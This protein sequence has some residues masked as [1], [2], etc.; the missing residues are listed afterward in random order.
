MQNDLISR[1]SVIDVLKE[2]G[3]VQDNNLG[4]LVIDEINRIPTAYDAEKVVEKV[5]DLNHYNLNLADKMID[6]Q[7]HSTA[8][9][10]YICAED[11]IEIIRKGGRND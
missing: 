7:K 5:A 9:R 6:I 8:H 4:H 10:H 1:S 2:T 3:I 11:A